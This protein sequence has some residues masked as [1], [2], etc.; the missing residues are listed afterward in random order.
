M[1]II[2]ILSSLIR[3]FT[4]SWQNRFAANL[5]SEIVFKAYDAILNE[6]YED[7]IKQPKSNLISII[8]MI[9]MVILNIIQPD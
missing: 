2:F 4:L 6:S 8:N 3:V 1:I 9:L 5:G 7:H